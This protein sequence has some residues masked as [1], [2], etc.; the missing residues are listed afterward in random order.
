M[1]VAY[2]TTVPQPSNATVDNYVYCGFV[3]MLVGSLVSTAWRALRL[4]MEEMASSYGG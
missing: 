2:I 3:A 4:Q 1:P